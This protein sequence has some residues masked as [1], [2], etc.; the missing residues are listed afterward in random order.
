MERWLIVQP[1]EAESKKAQ[2]MSET[3]LMRGVHQP[4]EIVQARSGIDSVERTVE[5]GSGV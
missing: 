3:A 5:A 2:N 4:M 1:R